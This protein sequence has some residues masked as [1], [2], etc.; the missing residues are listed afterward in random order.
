MRFFLNLDYFD[1]VVV[2]GEY[3]FELFF[4]EWVELFD[5]Y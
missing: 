1:V 5:V 4:G 3:V 2:L